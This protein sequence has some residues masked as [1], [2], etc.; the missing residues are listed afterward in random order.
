[1]V[2]I[3][4]QLSFTIT[5]VA[6]AILMLISA[7]HVPSLDKIALWF[8]NTSSSSPFMVTLATL[9]FLLFSMILD[10]SMLTPM[11]FALAIATSGLSGLAVRC[12][13]PHHIYVI[14]KTEAAD[15]PVTN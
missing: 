12:C 13:C 1:M 6:V 4:T 7:L 11:L 3:N 5:A 9:M 2:L 8:D 10:L 14:C 15:E